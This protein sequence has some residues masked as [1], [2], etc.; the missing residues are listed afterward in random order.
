MLSSTFHLHVLHAVL[1]LVQVPT[2]KSQGMQ[3]VRTFHPIPLVTLQDMRLLYP[4][5]VHRHKT[6]HQTCTMGN[7]RKVVT[8]FIRHV[9][10]VRSSLLHFCAAF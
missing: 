9:Q 1:N 5:H 2:Q 7:Q 4:R 6:L 10:R 8:T 3:V